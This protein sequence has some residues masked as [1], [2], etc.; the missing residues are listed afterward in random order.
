MGLKQYGIGALTSGPI[1][2]PVTVQTAVRHVG[3]HLVV[4]DGINP[5]KTARS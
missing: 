2:S 1:K 5:N 4:P 3:P